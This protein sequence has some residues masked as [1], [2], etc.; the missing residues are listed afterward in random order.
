MKLT[1]PEVSGRCRWCGCTDE[2]G[3]GL[4]CSWA[5]RSHT[6]CSACVPLDVSIRTG[7][8]RTALA[9]ALQ[10]HDFEALLGPRPRAARRPA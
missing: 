8:G 4:G 6:L 3:C 5:N 7:R 10:E 2:H 9:A 1:I